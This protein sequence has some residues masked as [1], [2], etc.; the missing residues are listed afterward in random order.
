MT[1]ASETTPRKQVDRT[2]VVHCSFAKKKLIVIYHNGHN[3]DHGKYSIKE[4]RFNGKSIPSEKISPSK[5]R[6][7]RDNICPLPDLINVD[8]VLDR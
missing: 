2:A 3:L 6:I 4:V 8:V 5:I 7:N 1:Y